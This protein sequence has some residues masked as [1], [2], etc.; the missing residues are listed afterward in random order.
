MLCSL[1]RFTS[2]SD[3]D[4]GAA[5]CEVFA[6]GRRT[7]NSSRRSTPES[8]VPFK[9]K[10]LL[11]IPTAWITQ[12]RLAARRS[13]TTRSAGGQPEGEPPAVHGRC[14]FSKTVVCNFMR[15]DDR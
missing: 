5:A 9:Y 10:L 15:F 13:D 8:E 14:G 6:R 12:G 7:T 2:G 4:R 1:Q 11:R 3:R